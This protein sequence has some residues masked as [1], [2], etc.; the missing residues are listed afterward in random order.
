M[1]Q[2]VGLA[3]KIIKNIGKIRNQITITIVVILLTSSF[4]GLVSVWADNFFGTSGPDSI[5][6]TNKNDKIFGRAGN[7][8]LRGEGG[9]DHIEGNVG[10]DEIH[11]GLGNDNMRW[12]RRR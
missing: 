2:K 7:D 6:G 11:D 1:Q 8:N 3:I 9:D 12:K 4:T 5:V 10:N